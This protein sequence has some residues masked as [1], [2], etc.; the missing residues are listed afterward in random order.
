MTHIPVLLKEVV[1]ILN[2]KPGDFIIDGT[3]GGGGHAE[4]IIKK[5][6]KGGMFLGMDL[7]KEAIELAELKLN[8][9]CQMSDVR[10]YFVHGN[11]ADL[12]EILSAQGGSVSGGKEEKLPRADGLLLDL[13][14]SSEQ[15]ESAGRR[16][17]RGFSF[18]RDEPLDMRYNAKSQNILTAAEVVNGFTEKEL[19]DIIFKYGEE[20]YSRRIAKAIIEERKKKRILTTFDLVEI[21]KKAVPGVY[22]RGRRHSAMR[23]FQALRIYVNR[24]LDNVETILKN[25][26]KILKPKGRV[27][28]ISFHSLED[29][30]AKN[31]FRQ[32]AKNEEAEILT[33][34]PIRPTEEEIEKNTRSKSAKLRAIQII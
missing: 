13:G 28:I 1:E 10:C 27:L 23:T 9:R 34:K 6:G 25:I 11:Y 3:I 26:N 7:D 2:S 22:Q 16:I 12:P 21:I 8:V 29:R 17:G 19:A 15:L 14:F 18:L 30:L 31:Y 4:E 5:I 24:E 20:R 33:K 32:M